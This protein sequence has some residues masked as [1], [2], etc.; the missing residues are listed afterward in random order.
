MHSLAQRRADT[1]R[2]ILVVL[3][4]V[5]VVI[6]A[7]AAQ[8]SIEVLPV[9]GNVHLLAG[10]GPNITLQIGPNGVL[11][12]D[13]PPPA[14]VP[15]VLAAIE[16]LTDWPIGYIINTHFDVEH[17]G[18]NGALGRPPDTPRPRGSGTLG[19]VP[20]FVLGGPA[21]V[22]ILA[23]ANII[24]RMVIPVA[25]E[26]P[27]PLDLVPTKDYFLPT[28]DF[29]FNGEPIILY[30]EPSAHTDGDSL[31][32][33][34]RSDV[35]STGDIFTPGRYP[36]IELDRGGSV[37]GLL[38]AL[39]HILRLTVPE[40]FQEGGTYVIPGHGRISEEADVVEYRDMIAIVRDRVQDLIDRGMSLEQV[41]AAGP[42][43][44]YDPEYAAASDP[45]ARDAFVDAVYRDLTQRED[46]AP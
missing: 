42:T 3:A 29:F 39:N 19:A 22:P 25:G 34:R 43:R 41:R 27:T 12:V 7:P 10:A 8:T 17:F 14:L 40:K 46:P 2:L 18:G 36:E 35:I 26:A 1:G 38:D 6:T 5:G 31:V 33:F 32:M 44:D 45:Q 16:T 9:Q 23:H 11:L 37:Q 20:E 24:R 30:H 28:M 4:V 15:Q 13:T 21:L